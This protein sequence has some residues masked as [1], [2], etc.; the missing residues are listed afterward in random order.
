MIGLLDATVVG[1]VLP[2]SVESVQVDANL[3][4]EEAVV[5]V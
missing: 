1:N 3:L 2:L 4:H 5:L